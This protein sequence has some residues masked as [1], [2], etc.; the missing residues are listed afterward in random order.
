M[1]TPL[2]PQLA[3][4]DP[5]R[6]GDG[7]RPLPRARLERLCR[8]SAGEEWAIPAVAT[9][10]RCS[11]RTIKRAR[12]HPLVRARIQFLRHQAAEQALED[13]PLAKRGNRVRLLGELAH[14]LAQQ[15]ADNKYR[16]VVGVTKQGE[17]IEG[18]D[19][20]RVAELVKTVVALDDMTTDKP[21]AQQQAT[22]GV[23]V[24]IEQAATKVQALLSR[25]ALPDPG[26]PPGRPL[27]VV[28]GISGFET[29]AIQGD[30]T[31]RG[32]Q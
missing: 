1:A 7:S 28:G 29:D 21:A 5:Q 24:T 4:L 31:A 30:G 32:P 11:P 17:P 25:V 9:A 8:L 18:F 27:G 20:G 19:R 10:L 2:L 22:V 23:A 15:L 3:G 12:Q 13:E 6:F 16:A 26:N 14:D